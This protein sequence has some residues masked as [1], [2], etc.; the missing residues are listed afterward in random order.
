MSQFSLPV[1]KGFSQRTEGE[2]NTARLPSSKEKS[3][4]ILKSL[5]RLP[6]NSVCADCT[7]KFP[8]WASLPHGVFICIKCAQV[9]RHIG[10]HISQVKALHTDLW[11]PDE[12]EAMRSMGNLNANNYYCAK[13]QLSKP[14]P[15][16]SFFEKEHFIRQKYERKRWIPSQE[17]PSSSQSGDSSNKTLSKKQQLEQR[18]AL[19]REQRSQ[20]AHEEPQFPSSS[21]PPSAPSPL[22]SSPSSLPSSSLPS[23][24]LP[25]LTSPE[26]ISQNILDDEPQS[27]VSF[28]TNFPPMTTPSSSQTSQQDSFNSPNYSQSSLP[29][30]LETSSLSPPGAQMS[31]TTQMPTQ[32]DFNCQPMAQPSSSSFQSCFP[33]IS[34]SVVGDSDLKTIDSESD[35]SAR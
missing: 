20:K 30:S 6:D 11:F 25:P 17:T 33:P 35:F 34:S 18:R 31:A 28:E 1:I 13:Y 27:F 7:E 26:L 10:R 5:L 22:S 16:N 3:S 9:H 29:F 24:S 8:S 32:F 2:K 12:L 23:S 21:A 4:S 14:T 19:K 15:E